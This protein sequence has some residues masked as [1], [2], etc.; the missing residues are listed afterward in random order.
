MNSKLKLV[1]PS[2]LLK[3]VVKWEM[4]RL[5]GPISG[6]AYSVSSFLLHSE[7]NQQVMGQFGQPYLSVELERLICTKQDRC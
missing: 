5:S 3:S 6:Q 7:V 2:F 4:E 1:I